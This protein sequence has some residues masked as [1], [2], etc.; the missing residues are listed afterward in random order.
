MIQAG[1]FS[2]NKDKWTEIDAVLTDSNLLNGGYVLAQK[3]KK[4]YYLILVK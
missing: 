2:I 1:G 4:K 3:G